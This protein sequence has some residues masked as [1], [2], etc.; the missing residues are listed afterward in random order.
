[1]LE[2]SGLHIY[3]GGIHALRGIS[4]SVPEGR[5][6]TL[7]GANGAGKSTVLRGI[8][9]LVEVRSGNISFLDQKIQNRPAH[10]IARRGI[11]LVPEGRRIF[12][13]LTVEE[14]LLMGSY[15]RTETAE[16]KEDL[17]R[18]YEIF[19]RLRERKKQKGGTLSGGEQQMLALGRGLMARPVLLMLDEPSMGLAPRL[20]RE[21]FSILHSIHREGMTILLV[22]QNAVAALH[23][24]HY[25]YVLQTGRVTLEGP[26][27][28]L[29]RD[30]SVKEAYLGQRLQ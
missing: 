18:V 26:G 14:N 20:V 13:N 4:I 21:V 23:A 6:V 8:S 9:G 30:S 28:V 17:K 5:I 27:E 15:A 7:I 16:E 25:G 22:E 29:L 3:Y 10:Q 1:L 2:V 12:G 24:A 11:A 19:P